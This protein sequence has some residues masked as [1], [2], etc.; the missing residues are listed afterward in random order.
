MAITNHERDEQIAVATIEARD[1]A[2]YRGEPV[3]FS[4]CLGG[5]CV[6]ELVRYGYGCPMC[7]VITVHPNGIVSRETKSN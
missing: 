1:E 4:A 5:A 6:F 7:E 2:A 3:S